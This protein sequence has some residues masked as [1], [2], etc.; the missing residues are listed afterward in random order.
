[1][2]IANKRI[3]ITGGAGFIGSALISRLIEN[4]KIT[5]FDNLNRNA[6]QH[7]TFSKHKNIELIKG[8]VL[9]LEYLMEASKDAQIFIHAA[10]IAGIDNTLKDPVNTLRVNMLGIANALEAIK[11][12]K[13][14]EK[15]IEFSTSEVFGSNAL[16]S[17][18]SDSAEI[19]AVGAA[20]WTY[21]ISKLAGEHLTHAYYKKHNLP[22]CTVRP[23]NVYG[24]GQVGEGAISVMVRRAI[25]DEPLIIFGN[26]SQ[27]RAWLYVDDMVDGLIKCLSNKKAIGESFNLGNAKAV[28]TIYGLAQIICKV[29]NSKSEIIFKDALSNDIELR[30]PNTD[31][32]KN[33]IDF[34]AKVGLEEGIKKTA[35]WIKENLDKLEALPEMFN[36]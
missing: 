30:I 32:A 11:N 17:E 33:L 27:I 4:N 16:N 7:T 34:E 10:G 26:G 35:S 23:F 20:R 36:S 15:F 3:F 21:A 24:P 28:T 31:K 29:L 25:N 1:M 18:E 8:D 12:S 22:N 2:V 6:I 19:G 9:N 14:I 13:S 5:V